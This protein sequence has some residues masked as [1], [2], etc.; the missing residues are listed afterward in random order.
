MTVYNDQ[1]AAIMAL[2]SFKPQLV[3]VF[4][5]VLKAR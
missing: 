4:L 3:R 1:D 5:L 2:V